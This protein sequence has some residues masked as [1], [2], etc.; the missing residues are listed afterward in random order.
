MAQ[1]VEK[2][3]I[4]ALSNPTSRAEATPENLMHWTDGG[5]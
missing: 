2:P 1:H 3:I 5:P 4:F